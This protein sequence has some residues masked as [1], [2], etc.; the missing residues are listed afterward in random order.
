[1]S[2]FRAYFVARQSGWFA[3][4]IATTAIA[5]QIYAVRHQALD[6]GLVGLI[7]FLPQLLLAVPAGLIADRLDRRAVVIITSIGALVGSL[8]FFVLALQHSQSIA[9]YFGALLLYSTADALGVPA[10]RAMLPSLVSGERYLRATA[11]ISSVSQ[12]GTIAGPA[13]A[14]VLIAFSAASAFAVAVVLQL[15]AI[16]A[17]FFLESRVPEEPHV[18]S[19]WQSSV[20]GFR[21]VIDRKII[22]GAI[23]LDLFAVLFGG[24]TALLPIYATQILHVGAT[25]YGMLRAAPAIGAAVVGLWLI[26]HPIQRNGGRWLFW[27][28]AGFGVATIVFGL[29]RNMPLSLVALAGT[30]GFD[31]VSVV[32]RIALTQL[33][34]PELMRGRVSAFENIFIGASNQLGTFES[35]AVAAWLGA[36]PSVVLG[37]CATIAVVVLWVGLFPALRKFDYLDLSSRA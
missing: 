15:V 14:G 30:G 35:G 19:L 33:G 13:V 26:R 37:G 27:C 36:V 9:D 25:G 20:G 34:V 21:F 12:F 4:G 28:I 1:M 7:G 18:E 29:S 6:L 31:M 2:P 23:S 22:L 16:V 3:E 8:L 10:M 32:I 5:W 11:L 24:A 17:F